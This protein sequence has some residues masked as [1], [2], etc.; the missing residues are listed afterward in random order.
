MMIDTKRRIMPKILGIFHALESYIVSDHGDDD[1][2][3][4]RERGIKRKEGEKP[5]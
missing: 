1:V 3:G 4:K 2:D 5:P